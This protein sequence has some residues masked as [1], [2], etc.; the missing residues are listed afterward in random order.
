MR[1]FPQSRNR[2]PTILPLDIDAPREPP[3]IVRPDRIAALLPSE[4]GTKRVLQKIFV[5]SMPSP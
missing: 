1:E 5:R 2:Q 4:N 3:S